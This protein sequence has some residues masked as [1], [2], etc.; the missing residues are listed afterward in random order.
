M[1]QINDY[2]ALTR[3]LLIW[4]NYNILLIMVILVSDIDFGYKTSTVVQI[5]ADQFKKYAW[6]AHNYTYLS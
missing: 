5:I 6:S 2:A 3:I 1:T 4:Q